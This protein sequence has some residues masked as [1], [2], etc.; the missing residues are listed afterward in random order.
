MKLVNA[1]SKALLLSGGLVL[2]SGPLQ[3][4]TITQS[5]GVTVVRGD[6]DASAAAQRRSSRGRAGVAVFRGESSTVP[7]AS[8]PMPSPAPAGISQVVGGQNLWVHDAASG[9]I[10][11]CNLRYDAYGNQN[12][13]CHSDQP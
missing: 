6:D 13:R 12:V 11:A 8:A 7:H 9:T 3:A 10:T 4:E 2:A 1:F 5:S